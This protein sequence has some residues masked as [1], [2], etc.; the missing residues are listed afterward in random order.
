MPE[1][2]FIMSVIFWAI[3]VIAFVILE[4]ATV[5]LVS[6]WLAAGSFITML[7]TYFFDLKP[8]A[9][10]IVFILSSAVLLL[11]TFPII[12]SRHKKFHIAT[13]ADLDIGKAAAVIEDI[14]PSCSTGRV[15]LNGVDW[16]AVSEN[17]ESIPKGVTVTVVAISGAKLIVRR[18]S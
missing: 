17:G 1:R 5:Q 10:L 14:E 18:S 7:C 11:I 9:Q 2:S 13:N 8:F 6:I 3:L 15:T 4:I 12:R 16:C